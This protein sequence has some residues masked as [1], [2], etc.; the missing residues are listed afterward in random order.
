[1]NSMRTDQ[2]GDR[3]VLVLF[4][5]VC[6]LCNGLVRFTVA[7]DPTSRFRFVSL[8]SEEARSKLLDSGLQPDQLDTIVVISEG[9]EFTRS[10]AVLQLLAGL[11]QPWPWLTVLRFL[12]LSWRDA[13]YRLLA[14]NRYRL[15]GRQDSC[16]LPR[17]QAR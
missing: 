1:M 9:S 12:P 17:P 7:R 6:N 5:G 16:P 11:R 2:N 10:E 4:D 15:F 13:G 3:E 14:R 8:Q